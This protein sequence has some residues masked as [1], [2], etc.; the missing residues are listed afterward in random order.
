MS[1]A[2]RRIRRH[3]RTIAA[4]ALA[5]T[6]ASTS[7]CTDAHGKPN[8]FGIPLPSISKSSDDELTEREYRQLDVFESMVRNP[9]AD[10]DAEIRV[11]AAEELIAMDIQPATDR[12]CAAL[13]S[14]EPVVVSAVIDAIEASPEPIDGV[15]SAL[16]E[17]L[18]DASDEQM[19]KLFLVL[20]RYGD[21]ALT[22]VATAARDRSEP[23]ARRVGP[24]S[25]LAAFRSRDAAIQLMAM[26]Q[27]PEPQPPEIVAATGAS[28]EQLTGLPYGAEADQWRRWWD[29]LKDEPIENWLRVM[30]LHLSTRTAELE[31]ENHLQT[32]E[33][34][35]IALRLTTTLRELFL[36]MGA[37]EQIARLPNLLGDDLAPV[38]AFALGRVERRLRDSERIP[39]AVQAK[40]AE[41]LADTDELPTS[42]LLAARLLNELNYQ[43]TSYLVAAAIVE[44]TD[45]TIAVGY[46][47]IMAKRPSPT[48]L[49]QVLIWLN[50]STAG[51]AAG[52]ALWTMIVREMVA[53]D[54]AIV[55][56]SVRQALQWQTEPTPQLIRLLAA[57]GDDADRKRVEELLDAQDD[58]LR[59]AAA[60][61]LAFA[62]ELEPLLRRADDPQIFPFVIGLLAAGSGNV[63]TV[64]TLAALVPPQEH[65]QR[66]AQTIRT[67][68]DAMT[69]A[70]LIA[71]DQVLSRFDHVNPELRAAIL[72]RVPG[73]PNDALTT[74]QRSE[75]LVRL[76]RLRIDLGAFQTAYDALEWPN[77]AP[78]T[79]ALLDIQFE[80]AVLSGRYEEAA[81]L[82]DNVR[83]WLALL[84]TLIGIQSPAA[85]EVRDE[86]RTRFPNDLQF[87]A[88]EVFR[89][90]ERRLQETTVTAGANTGSTQ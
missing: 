90:A 56:R 20:P 13:R 55:R 17:T 44:E 30:V 86:I 48:A 2:F 11:A 5:L 51:D 16:T 23:P 8:L 46:M 74:N 47:E 60:E 19:E 75:L 85:L 14:G 50:D 36:V 25:A 65:R 9:S 67:T 18:S 27:D 21:E 7:A 3:G 28:L 24:I 39:E 68:A 72:A 42:R 71:V 1:T 10:I 40:L 73:L 64:R 15:L 63:D 22:L 69:P 82:N 89:A 66:W 76:A 62:G 81:E 80:A 34:Q 83:V 38:R 6:V 26:L 32:R 4:A 79:P 35:E 54:D 33:R 45:A 31:R 87:E 37:D 78:T 70:D 84:D 43:G 29:K 57:I 12:L 59:R 49:P 52:D 53:T 41:R 58:D 77:G 61:G 88:G